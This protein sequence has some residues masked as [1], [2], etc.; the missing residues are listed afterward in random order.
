MATSQAEQFVTVPSAADYSAAG[1]G[2]HKL[3][4][5]NTS[6]QAVVQ[7]SAGG[8]VVGVLANKPPAANRPAKVQVGGIATIECGGNI[9]AGDNVRAHTDGTIITAAAS[10]CV[11]GVAL[12]SGSDG[13]V[14]RVLL[15]S[16]HILA[17]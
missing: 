6:G 11:I 7:T 5:I 9:T 13:A 16:N 3:V 4:N 1:A 10:D 12:E 15:V 8:R 2:L 17:A 14:I